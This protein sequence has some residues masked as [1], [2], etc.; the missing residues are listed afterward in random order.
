MYVTQVTGREVKDGQFSTD[1]QKSAAWGDKGQDLVN[2]YR[3]EKGL[4]PLEWLDSLHAQAFNHCQQMQTDGIISHDGSDARWT[5][6]QSWY[7][8]VR[9]FAEN[10]AYNMDDPIENAVETAVTQWIESPG[11]EANMTGDFNEAG[12]GVYQKEGTREVYLTQ[13]F[14]NNP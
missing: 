7:V 4:A 8:G 9:G 2:K 5:E 6:I 14:I 11:H 3:V 10:V 13:I 1:A 12:M